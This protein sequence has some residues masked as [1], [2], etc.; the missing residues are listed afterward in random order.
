MPS[1]SI[2]ATIHQRD[3]FFAAFYRLY[4][5]RVVQLQKMLDENIYVEDWGDHSKNISIKEH[6]QL[7][8]FLKELL[9]KY[10]SRVDG[11][12]EFAKRP[13]TLSEL[14]ETTLISAW[15]EIWKGILKSQHY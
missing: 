2:A 4:L 9:Q 7:A 10:Q 14:A 8:T 15:T 12:K 5:T 6:P 11:L 13:A 1:K 3:L